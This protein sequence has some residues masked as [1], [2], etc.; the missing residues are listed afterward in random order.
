MA[1]DASVSPSRCVEALT[2][3]FL[4]NEMSRE[5]RDPGDTKCFRSWERPE[6]REESRWKTEERGW[7]RRVSEE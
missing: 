5:G 7:G 6:R 3:N 1:L 4:M 2:Y